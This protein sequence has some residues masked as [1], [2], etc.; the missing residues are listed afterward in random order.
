V[1]DSNTSIHPYTGYLLQSRTTPKQQ[2]PRSGFGA[3]VQGKYAKEKARLATA[4]RRTR[5]DGG[6]YRR[7]LPNTW[8]QV[9]CGESKSSAAQHPKA[10]VEG[11][12]TCGRWCH[13]SRG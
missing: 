10:S 5:A 9:W 6:G 13:G 1:R 8:W 3:S 12:N 4:P 11:E 2:L 7:A